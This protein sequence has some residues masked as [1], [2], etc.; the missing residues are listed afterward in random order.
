MMTLTRDLGLVLRLPSRR[1]R[2]LGQAVIE[3][4]AA[5]LGL[6]ADHTH[7]LSGSITSDSPTAPLSRAQMGLIDDVTFAIPRVAARL[8][9]RADCM[10]QALAAKRWLGRHDIVTQLVIGARTD[11]TN[12]LD[13]HAWLKAGE[14]IVT[15]GD[16]T[17][18]TPF[19]R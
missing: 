3:L 2:A 12:P 4:A 8:P 11:G 16:T 13:A 18:F 5:R 6:G 9:W 14:R 15:G 7:H 17:G 19:A 1:W 10:V